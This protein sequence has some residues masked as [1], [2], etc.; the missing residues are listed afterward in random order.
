V[1]TGASHEGEPLAAAGGWTLAL[2]PARADAFRKGAPMRRAGRPF[3]E[4]CEAL[5]TDPEAAECAWE[6]GA[7]SDGREFKRT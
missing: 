3:E 4:M 6:K 2:I 5:R 1:P 7:A